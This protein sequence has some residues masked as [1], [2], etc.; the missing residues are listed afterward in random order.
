MR[1][2][3]AKW[4][5]KLDR[6][7]AKLRRR[8]LAP[9]VALHA[10]GG[11]GASAYAAYRAAQEAGNRRKLDKQWVVE[12]HIAW[13]AAYVDRS[14]GPV[15]FGLCHGTRRGAEQAWFRAHLPGGPRVIGTEIS[16]T[17]TD[18][19]D[20][21]QWDFHDMNEDWRGR[22]DFVYS[23]SW[24]H[25]FDPARAFRA[26]AESLRPGG[27]MLLDHSAGHSV[28]QAGSNINATDPFAADLD[29]LPGWLDAT[30]G[31][32]GRTVEV[33]DTQGRTMGRPY[34]V[35]VFRRSGG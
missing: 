19:P 32:L 26:W 14:L 8:R 33:L 15:S 3:I 24:D 1:A 9:G 25:A 13:L 34:H 17:A 16:S 18:F 30:L 4:R 21:V 7:L 20:T 5:R 11:D 2:L 28:S 35:V 6:Q 22:A 12:A 29:A 27:L 10:Y 31:D 23:N